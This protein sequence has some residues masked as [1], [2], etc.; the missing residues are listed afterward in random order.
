MNFR[1]IFHASFPG[2]FCFGHCF[3]ELEGFFD[4]GSSQAPSMDSPV[5]SEMSDNTST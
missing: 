5:A 1:Q 2:S 4:F 3:N